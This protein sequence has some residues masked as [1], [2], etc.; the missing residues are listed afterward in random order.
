[1]QSTLKIV[2]A[3][4]GTGGHLYPALNIAQAIRQR[5]PSEI[6]FFGTKRG[7]EKEKAPAAGF[8]VRF[9][10]VAGLQ[11]RLT[12]KNLTVP[13]KLAASLYMCRKTLK[14][15]APHLVIGTGGYVMGPALRTAQSMNIPT[16]L[17]EQNIFPGMTTRLLAP[18]AEYVF[19]PAEAAKKYFKRQDNLLVTGN[20]LPVRQSDEKRGDILKSFGLKEDKQTVLVFGGSQGA[21][22]INSAVTELLGKDALPPDVQILW[23]TGTRHYERIRQLQGQKGW[24]GV[25]VVPFID[26]MYRAY[27]AADLAVCR[28][29]AMALAELTQAGLPAILIPYPSSSGDHQTLNAVA[30]SDKNAA[31]V[32]K[33]DSNLTDQLQEALKTV[34]EIPQLLSVMSDNMRAMHRADAL[35]IILKKIDELIERHYGQV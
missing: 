19:L 22:S 26:P 35:E 9:I 7:L 16:V 32:L 18:K 12:L 15:F 29:G 20:P 8:D 30:L 10:P 31:M 33:D 21:A 34:F 11:R 13:L 6:L 4:G 24:Q 28:A 1:M 25:A 3:G 27:A 5:R 2:F 23:Q 14:Q 17:Q